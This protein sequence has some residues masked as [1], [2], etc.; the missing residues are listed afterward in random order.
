MRAQPSPRTSGRTASWLS[1]AVVG[2]AAVRL[3]RCSGADGGIARVTVASSPRGDSTDNPRDAG[4]HPQRGDLVALVDRGEVQTG[5]RTGRGG[6]LW[7]MPR[8][9]QS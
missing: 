6:A 9:C 2:A 4:A 3:M 8:F 7:V 5:G 1:H